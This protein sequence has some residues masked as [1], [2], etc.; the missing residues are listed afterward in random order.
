MDYTINNRPLGAGY[1]AAGEP[2]SLVE[3]KTLFVSGIEPA[4]SSLTISGNV[5]INGTVSAYNLA[6]GTTLG[7]LL[8]SINALD[9]VSPGTVIVF[10]PAVTS[11]NAATT[12]TITNY[13]LQTFEATDAA[14]ARTTLGLGNLAT[15]NDISTFNIA[16]L[17][18]V[19]STAPTNGDVLTYNGGTWN[20]AA[21]TG[22]TGGTGFVV[23]NVPT[24]T[25]PTT[26]AGTTLNF[27][28]TSNK[29]VIDGTGS[30]TINF[31]VCE[32][33]FTNIPQTSV[34]NLTTDLGNRPTTTYVNT[35]FLA[36]STNFDGL[37]DVA[38]GGASNGQIVYYNGS[39]WV[40][41]SPTASPLNLATTGYIAGLGY[42][43]VS[44][45][46]NY[47]TTSFAATNYLTTATV[48]DGLADV[49][50]TSPTHNQILVYT[51]A[52]NSW[53]N[54][55]NTGGAGTPYFQTVDVPTG[56]DPVATTGQT[57]LTLQST[58]NKIIIN[59]AGS[60][61]INFSVCETNFT[62]IP[63][64]SIVNLV[65]DLSD[66][67]STSYVNSNFLATSTNFDGL[68]DVNVGGATTGEII[69]Y[70]GTNWTDIS[71]TA[72][73]LNLATTGYIAGLGYATTSQLGS[74]LLTSV[75][76]TTYLATSTNFDGLA[77]VSVG[78]ASNGQIVYYNGSN[79]VNLSPTASP[80]NLAT[81]GYIASLGYATVSQLGN[82]V[83]TSFASTN[84]L[85]TATVL[86]DLADVSITATTGHV[87][88]YN[89]SNWENTS[90]TG[91]A[92]NL[93]TTGYVASNFLANSTI[94][95]TVQAY[96]DSLNKLGSI[97]GG[98]ANADW[99]KIPF[100]KTNTAGVSGWA[101]LSGGPSLYGRIIRLLDPFAGVVGFENQVGE[102]AWG[103]L[104]LQEL[105]NVSVTSPTTGHV[106]YYNGSNWANL[107]PTAAPLNLATTGYVAGLGY[108]TTGQLSNYVT[109]SFANSNYLAT[110]TNFDGLADV[111]IT[112]ASNGEIVYFTGSNWVN[113]SPTASPLNLATT[114]YIA[115]LGYVTTGS[116]SNYLTTATILDD[117][118]DVEAPT[119]DVG[120]VLY[121]NGSEWRAAK[122]GFG[123]GQVEPG[124]FLIGDLGNVQRSTTVSS[125]A[126]FA[127]LEDGS[128]LTWNGT[129]GVWQGDTLSNWVPLHVVP[130]LSANFV[131]AGGGTYLYN[132]RV[133]SLSAV[134]LSATNISG[135]RVV[136]SGL[137]SIDISATNY[138]N[139][140]SSTITWKEAQDIVLTVRNETGSTLAIAT[141]VTISG[142]QGDVPVVT[143]LSSVN[144][145]VP[146]A[147]GF[148]NH[149]AG[150]IHT[151][152]DNNQNGHI[153]VEGIIEGT[154]DYP[155]NTSAFAA[156]DFLYV[157]SNGQLANT[158]PP[159]PYE[160][161]PVGIVLRSH[162]NAGKILVK[163]ENS[164]E[165]NDIVGFNLA[166][167]L[168]NG[169]IITYDL[170]TSTFINRQSINISGTIRGSTVSAT[171]ISATNFSGISLSGSLRDVQITSP[172]NDYVL[173]WSATAGKWVPKAAPG[174]T[175]GIANGFATIQDES[176]NPLAATGEDIVR[177]VSRDDAIVISLDTGTTPQEV[178]FEVDE[179]AV[180]H[181]NLFGL[182]TGNPHT[183]YATLS[184]S[185]FTGQVRAPSVSA[186]S[187]IFTNLSAI[188][189]SAT[190]YLNI[191]SGTPIWN[192]NQIQ[193]VNVSST[194]P[195]TGD[196]LTYD[197]AGWKPSAP[198]G[199]SL[200]LSLLVSNNLIG[201]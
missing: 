184:G 115:G 99:G 135:T 80:L 78:A 144:T 101:Y 84:Y 125:D 120:H 10:N 193:D 61:T 175:G 104:N 16:D 85:T 27:G 51:T 74:Y 95:T 130:N 86:N 34:A 44:Q 79:W 56:T 185:V 38:V 181:N 149:V 62:G 139:L 133:S 167:N 165:L 17:N 25:D 143:I 6:G 116:L 177:F 28:S 69:Y 7:P 19:G 57:T 121:W 155:L 14:E 137:S 188:T 132:Y 162:P 186:T 21:P 122:V 171:T 153:V 138:Y 107:S 63:Q 124:E 50:I 82:Y 170:D 195:T 174:S 152:I 15:L 106:L 47:V 173:T 54:G 94:G 118:A 128:P 163:I 126:F 127:F 111:S 41:L 55:T 59:G 58:S 67:A 66:K 22:G 98:T 45:L 42:A 187:G 26:G 151:S 33:N 96:S 1:D 166:S 199:G 108:A 194:A 196:V 168:I 87:L 114:G 183:Q 176:G 113:I 129:S 46:G 43:T 3:L 49:A 32:T 172:T 64:T 147:Y 4:A 119:P 158:R 75:A 31:S 180:V 142:V 110:S 8:A 102:P 90:P 148:A 190:N 117:L 154:D 48:L 70:N 11:V 2:R 40:N 189:L 136:A 198:A 164:P 131:S 12:A 30:N 92:L 52:T 77:D 112:G 141:P 100:T 157:S 37:A 161:H 89:G 65:T 105:Q 200:G 20:A 24:G 36:T 160:A 109:T 18:N 72:S 146:E 39:N 13:A 140:P 150:L 71:P 123:V 197:G 103:F 169:D 134:N 91:T 73:P 53:V 156:G 182:T 145:H 68:A 159:A 83:T 81:T 35:N 88:Y 29:V 192:A 191:P 23:V 97:G 178:N 93:A 60:N 9:P 76:A 179:S 201:Y 5:T